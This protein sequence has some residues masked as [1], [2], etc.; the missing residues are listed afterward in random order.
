MDEMQRLRVGLARSAGLPDSMADKIEGRS[1]EELVASATALPGSHPN[2]AELAT[3]SVQKDEQG[4]ALLRALHGERIPEPNPDAEPDFDGGV[5][6]PAPEPE[7]P[8]QEHN[9]LILRVI[10]EGR[11]LW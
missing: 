5:R 2:K 3:L 9:E 6:E 8:E 7:D 4:S 10:Q 11:G 1:I